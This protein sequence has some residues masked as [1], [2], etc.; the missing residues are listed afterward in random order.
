M[1]FF[2]EKLR[3]TIT[4]V[5]VALV[6]VALSLYFFEKELLFVGVGKIADFPLFWLGVIYLLVGCLRGITLVP[7]TVLI[8]LGLVF[9]PPWP[10][11]ILTMIGIM[12]SSIFVYYFSEYLGL[13]NY[14]REKHQRS[15]T[16]LT[17]VLQKNELPIVIGWSFF[18]FVPTDVV[19]YVCGTLGV[20]IKKLLLGV[21][22]GEAVTCAIYIFVGK[23]LLLVTTN[24]MFSI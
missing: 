15:I 8:V 16:K 14:F 11:F 24:S 19:V 20:D 3:K 22:I 6:V 4:V 10:A 5:W 7:V 12:V 18:P 17:A 2:A 23:D 1:K 13:A 9:L 21:F